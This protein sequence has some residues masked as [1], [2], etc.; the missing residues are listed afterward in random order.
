MSTQYKAL[1]EITQWD[2]QNNNGINDAGEPQLDVDFIAW[3]PFPGSNICDGR[4]LTNANKVDGSW[5]AATTE[6]M[7]INN[8]NH[9]KR[10]MKNK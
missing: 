3:G 2:D 6:T 1:K 4:D 9:P 5:L 7:T 8:A 10:I